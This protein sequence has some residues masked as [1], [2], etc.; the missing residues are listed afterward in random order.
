MQVTSIYP[1]NDHIQR[2]AG[3]PADAD[4]IGSFTAALENTTAG[5]HLPEGD[6]SLPGVQIGWSPPWLGDAN[7]DSLLLSVDD[8]LIREREGHLRQD[9]P[10]VRAFMDATGLDA[11]A[12][13]SLL[14]GVVGAAPDLRDWAAIMTSNDP[15]NAARQATAAQLNSADHVTFVNSILKGKGY[16]P[17]AK[18]KIVAQAGNFAVV[19]DGVTPS[20][21]P[22]LTL[23][24]ID[25]GGFARGVLGW[26]AP[27]ILAGAEKYGVDLAPL[28]DLADQLDAKGVRYKPYELYNGSDRGVDLRS[29]A[30]GGMGSAYDW[31]SDRLVHLKGDGAAASLKF[32]Q[33]LAARLA[34]TRI[35]AE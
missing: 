17:V 3:A 8:Y 28:H 34:L 1:N 11:K 22:R 9:K 13:G 27:D 6:A 15:A 19:D 4:A 32:A 26:S 31:T 20:G 29:L 35:F 5:E 14:Y 18:D 16:E 12:A 7:P 2:G 23:R 33:E 30:N 21:Q 10:T 24:I 25:S